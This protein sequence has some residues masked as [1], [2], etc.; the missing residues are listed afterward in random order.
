MTGCS[1]RR[2]QVYGRIVFVRVGAVLLAQGVREIANNIMTPERYVATVGPSLS[3][4]R[5]TNLPPAYLANGLF[6]ICP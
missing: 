5:Q 1:D 4:L 2:A 3:D 6:A